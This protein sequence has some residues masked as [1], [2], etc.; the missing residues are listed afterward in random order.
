MSSTTVVMDWRH[1][2]VFFK[3]F[4]SRDGATTTTNAMARIE[5]PKVEGRLVPVIPERDLT[6]LLAACVCDHEDRHLRDRSPN[7]KAACTFANV[8]DRAIIRLLLVGLRHDEVGLDRAAVDETEQ[9]LTVRGKGDKV[10]L[11]SYGDKAADA[12]DDYLRLRKKH[13][14]SGEA[15]LWLA[16]PPKT[17]TFGYDGVRLMLNRRCR[18]AGIARLNPHRFR[19]TTIDD[20][21]ADGMSEGDVAAIVGHANTTM[22][23]TVY[24]R[25]R[26]MRRA[27]DSARRTGFGDRH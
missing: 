27:V 11:V 23:H 18:Q 19:H 12:L 9:L 4:S 21:L 14:A 5:K 17:G 26:A 10:R 24:A 1:L 3:W 2:K 20:A 16:T 8:R 25:D 22:I 6:A 15:E 7:R 13:V